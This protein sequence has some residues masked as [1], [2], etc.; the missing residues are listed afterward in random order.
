MR[1]YNTKRKFKVNFANN[2]KSI[3]SDLHGNGCSQIS[4][5]FKKEVI[6]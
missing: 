3:E 6:K 2:N 4:E 5:H 1:Q